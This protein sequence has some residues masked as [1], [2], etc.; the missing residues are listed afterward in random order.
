VLQPFDLPATPTIPREVYRGIEIEQ[1]FRSGVLWV[2][3]VFVQRP[4]GIEGDDERIVA[5]PVD[6]RTVVHF[7]LQG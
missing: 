3:P 1:F 4:W 2:V 6:L 7:S 5:E